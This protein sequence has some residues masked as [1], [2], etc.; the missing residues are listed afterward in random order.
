MSSSDVLWRLGAVARF[1]WWEFRVENPP[2]IVL[3]AMLPRAILQCLFF[4]LLGTVVGLADSSYSFTGSLAVIL[5]LSGAIG[6]MDVPM[7]DKWSGTFHRVRSGVLPP[8]LI[9]VLRSLPYTALGFFY[10]VISLLLVAP[11]T[12]NTDMILPLLPWLPV[13]LL[14]AWTTSAAGLAG[15]AMAVGRRADAFM[16]NLLAYLILLASGVLIPEGRMPWVDAIGSVLPARHGLLA[17]RAGLEGQPWLGELG[18]ELAVGGAWLLLAGLIVSVQ[19]RRAHRQ[20]FDDF[21]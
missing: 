9:F 21:A 12:G 2:K 14:M 16:G 10:A 7:L 18:L 20:G 6:V 8:F 19:V 4:T 13:Y 1:G 11:L 15:A 5:T 3:T 17:V